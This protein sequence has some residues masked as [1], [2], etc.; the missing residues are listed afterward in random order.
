MLSD[1]LLHIIEDEN[2]Q[3]RER[4]LAN[5]SESISGIN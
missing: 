2:N 5:Y 1:N 3:N 4:T